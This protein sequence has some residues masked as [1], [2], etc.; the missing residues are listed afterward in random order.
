MV[1]IVFKTSGRDGKKIKVKTNSF[2]EFKKLSEEERK[3]STAN[4]DKRLIKKSNKVLRTKVSIYDKGEDEITL[5]DKEGNFID[6]FYVKTI[7]I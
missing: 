7:K 6:L 3:T 1:K 5:L 2:K 4:F